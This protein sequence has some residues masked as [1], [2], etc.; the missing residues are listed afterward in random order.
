[1]PLNGGKI[2]AI[3][4]DAFIIRSGGKVTVASVPS[5]LGFQ[6]EGSAVEF[7]QALYDRQTEARPS[8]AFFCASLPRPNEDMMRGISSSGIP[9]PLSRTA[10]YDR[11]S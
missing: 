6:G 9:G 3:A 7:D 5:Q 10:T 2:L 11:R 8:S 4:G 1:L